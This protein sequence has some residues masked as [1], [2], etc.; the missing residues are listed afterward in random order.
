MGIFKKIGKGIKKVFKKVGKTI[1]KLFKKVGKLVNKAG[2]L[3]QI[4]MMFILPA[5][6]GFLMKGITGL[7]KGIV[8]ATQAGTTTAANVSQAAV[9]AGDAAGATTSEIAAGEAAKKSLAKQV[10]KKVIEKTAEGAWKATRGTGLLGSSSGLAN[11]VGTVLN[12]A[13][14]FVKAGVKAFSTVTEGITSFIG[15]FVKTGLN[16]IPGISIE[17]GAATF[18]EAWQNV[19]NNIMKNSSATVE[20]FNKSIGIKPTPGEFGSPGYKVPENVTIASTAA[21]N[22]S[23]ITLP[24]SPVYGTPPSATEGTF[25]QT[26]RGMEHPS[27]AVGPTDLPSDWTSQIDYPPTNQNAVPI[28]VSSATGVPPQPYSPVS[29]T[30]PSA[31]EGTFLPDSPVYGTPPSATGVPPQPDSL[32]APPTLPSDQAALIKSAKN[33]FTPIRELYAATQK[34][35]IPEPQGFWR[36]L[37]DDTVAAVREMPENMR[38]SFLELPD[39]VAQMPAD[40][41]KNAADTVTNLPAMGATAALNR[42]RAAYAPQ[43]SVAIG[44]VPDFHMPQNDPFEPTDNYIVQLYEN[45]QRSGQENY[46]FYNPFGYS[47]FMGKHLS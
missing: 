8:G 40:I 11:G 34:G 26:A 42:P 21:K 46:G 37:L 44:D 5:I 16:Q 1:K 32:L 24:D 14:N 25:L 30:P 2:I 15:E 23:D 19:Q 6:G 17:S 4:G 7:F 3:G 20:A 35:I 22:V 43:S 45:P 18:G 41:V 31:T 9:A 13:G 27:A 12:S 29:G 10:S 47:Q 33:T 39:K 36:G 38:T 28:D